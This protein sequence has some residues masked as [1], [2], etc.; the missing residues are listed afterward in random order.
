[1]ERDN[2]HSGLSAKCHDIGVAVG[3]IIAK[4]G[5]ILMMQRAGSTGEGTW[6]IPGGAVEFKESPEEAAVRETMEET[7]IE[8]N[9]LEFL[10][11]TNDIHEEKPLHYVTLRFFTSSFDGTPKI[12]EPDKC[13]SMGWFPIHSLPSPLFKPTERILSRND[14]IERINKS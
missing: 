14:V 6:A 8:V 13:T 4:N 2:N 10:G 12:T 5:E 1:M 7:G 11:Y 9:N 3:I